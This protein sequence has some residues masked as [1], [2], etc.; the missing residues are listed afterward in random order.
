M[1]GSPTVLVYS[2]HGAARFRDWLLQHGIAADLRAASSPEEAE[3]VIGEVDVILGWKIPPSLFSRATR[4]RWIQSMG[5]GVDDL[6]NATTLRPDVVVT[7][8]VDQFGGPIAEYVFAELLARVRELDRLRRLQIERT[9]EHFVAG[10]LAGRRIGVAGLGSI[11]TEIVRKARAFDMCVSGLSRSPDRASLV[12]RHFGPNQ[13]EE[14][15]PDL[16][17]LAL[18]LPLTPS[19]R[20]VVNAQVLAAM[21]PDSVL[22]NVGRGALVDEDALIDALRLGRP[23]GAVLDVFVTEPLPPDSPLWSLPGVV[24]TPHVSGPSTDEGVGQFFLENLQRYAQ[25]EPLLGVVNRDLGY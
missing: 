13:W 10:T 24:V 18:T 25:G 15:V 16:D 14:F 20:G 7:R 12:D 1:E 23:S 19:T 21:R 3:A 9:W 17:F 6:M 22:V 8:I 5:A 2:R 4:L 11:G